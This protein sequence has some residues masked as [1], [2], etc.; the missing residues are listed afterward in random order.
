MQIHK[1]DG[2]TPVT[3]TL[4]TIHE[5]RLILDLIGVCTSKIDTTYGVNSVAMYD[6]LKAGSPVGEQLS[7]ESKLPDM[8]LVY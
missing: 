2:Y 5:Y 8:K 4:E 3:I 1:S 7:D 6:L